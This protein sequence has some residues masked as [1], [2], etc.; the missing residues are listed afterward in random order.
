VWAQQGFADRSA[1][2]CHPCRVCVLQAVACTCV[3]VLC[4]PRLLLVCVP[5][6]GCWAW[7]ASHHTT[8]AAPMSSSS[9]ATPS[10]TCM[11]DFKVTM[12]LGKGSFGS[13]YK[14]KRRSDG[15]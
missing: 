5:F 15:F 9:A 12:L 2:P 14:C 3:R 11:R 13:V 6:G 10:P 1:T 4:V 8:P 7:G